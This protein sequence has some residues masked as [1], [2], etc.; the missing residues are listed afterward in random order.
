MKI[1]NFGSCNI[2]YVYSVKNIVRP[3]ET[4]RAS[5]LCKYPGGKG[6]N[7]SIALARAGAEVYH[8]GCVG[9]D[10]DILRK[11]LNESGVNTDY[12]RVAEDH[13]GQAI[14]QVE[15]SGENSIVLYNGANFCVDKAYVDEVL[16]N[17]SEGDILVLQNEISNVPYIV[18]RGKEKGMKIFLNPSPF[19][20]VISE[21]D[22]DDIYCIILNETEAESFGFTDFFREV[23][24]KHPK[25]R[26]VLTLGSK[27]SVY[28]FRD[29][30]IRQTAY[31]VNDV[32][33]T[34]AGDTFTG[35]F[36]S[37]YADGN[38]QNAM[39]LASTAA[40]IAA[41]RSGAAPSIPCMDEV[42]KASKSFKSSL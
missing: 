8:A 37:A 16:G 13:T 11:I 31:K 23:K 14:I 35:Y 3:G 32:D 18:K 36:I 33:T 30:C 5:G 10:D 41:S 1:L 24:D 25:L 7:Q 9:R 28:T 27:G 19:N 15:D 40:G 39:L 2:D 42:I 38:I 22:L 20:E 17:F 29:E 12:L 34:A 6:L 21:I 26:V 4:I